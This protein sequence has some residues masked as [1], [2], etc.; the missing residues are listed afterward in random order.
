MSPEVARGSC[1]QRLCPQRFGSPKSSIA[2]HATLVPKPR[3]QPENAQAVWHTARHTNLTD[4]Q[5]EETIMNINRTHAQLSAAIREHALVNAKLN[6]S[7]LS[8]IGGL[9]C[10]FRAFYTALRIREL[11]E[12]LHAK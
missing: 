3:Q 7:R 1:P 12:R 4:D 9:V 2:H 5:G 6:S 10:R 11:V 8:L